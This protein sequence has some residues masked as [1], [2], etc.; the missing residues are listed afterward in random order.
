MARRGCAIRTRAVQRTTTLLLLRLR[1]HII[2]QRGAEETA[3]LAQECR[4]VGFAGTPETPQWL[5]DAEV[6]QLLQAEPDANIVPQQASQ[7]IGRILD[8]M[9]HLQEPLSALAEHTGQKLLEE[10]R[11]VRA[12]LLDIMGVRTSVQPQLPPD[13]PGLYV[14]LPVAA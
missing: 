11:R 12:L 3:L 2:T 14:M 9:G 1:F 8:G 7:F 6:E 5:S 10:H 4:L 13:A